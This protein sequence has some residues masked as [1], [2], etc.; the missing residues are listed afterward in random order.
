MTGLNKYLRSVLDYIYRKYVRIMQIGKHKDSL[1]GLHHIG[2]FVALNN[3]SHK[4]EVAM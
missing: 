3:S 4:L 1:A 2:D